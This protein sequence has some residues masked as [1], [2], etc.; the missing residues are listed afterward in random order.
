MKDMIRDNTPS[1][2]NKMIDEETLRNL[3]R[4]KDAAPEE[5]EE[6]LKFLEKSY[7]IE[8]FVEA[9]AA[10]LTLG[11]IAL[12]FKNRKFLA[13]PLVAQGLLLSHSLPFAD[14]VTPLLRGFGLW[15]RQEIERERNAL[16]LL[17]GD[18]ERV[19]EDRTA[20]SALSAAQGDKGIKQA[21]AKTERKPRA[22]ANTPG[23]VPLAEAASFEQPAGEDLR[24]MDVPTVSGPSGNPDFQH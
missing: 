9:G 10:L 17:R 20:K 3:D 21:T 2:I 23:K 18:Y 5:I 12:G 15:S 6:R 7:D 4:Y 13:L 16:K 8:F 19:A 22:K 1:A 11:G 14:P 24:P